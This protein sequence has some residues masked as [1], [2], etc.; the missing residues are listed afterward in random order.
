MAEKK[1][2]RRAYLKDYERDEGGGYAYR[3]A[4]YECA[5]G[6]EGFHRERR[7]IAALGIS[8]VLCLVAAGLIDAP[9]AWKSLPATVSYVAGLCCCVSLCWS[10]IR[11]ARCDYPLREHVYK[12]T[13]ERIPGSAL[14]A[15]LCCA[16]CLISTFFSLFSGGGLS[17][18]AGELLA[19]L[20]FS[21]LLAIALFA[22]AAAGWL[23]A[24]IPWVRA[25]GEKPQAK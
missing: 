11:L 8:C 1:E 24:K 19:C 21:A 5:G 13:A 15:A 4:L 25:E 10:A 23:A 2:G 20:G 6:M 16:A 9:F 12:E 17:R 14:L 18:P 22:S 3:G 7:K